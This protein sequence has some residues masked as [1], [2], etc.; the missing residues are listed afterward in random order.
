MYSVKYGIPGIAAFFLGHIFADLAWYSIISF[1][2]AR[3]MRFFDDRFYR[4]LIGVCA[5]FLVIFSGYF[6]YSGVD[7]IYP[8][9][10]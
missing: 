5:T 4:R 1:G 2:I 6:F 3:G 9:L 8:S 7:R 10:L